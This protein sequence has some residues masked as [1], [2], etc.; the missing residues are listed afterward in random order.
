MSVPEAH[1]DA[2]FGVCF[3]PDSTRVASGGA[4]KYVR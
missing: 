1:T 2:I 3:S 4:D